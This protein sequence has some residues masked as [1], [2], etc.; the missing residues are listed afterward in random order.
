MS[1]LK[2]PISVQYELT[3]RCPHH[4][5]G[6]YNHLRGPIDNLVQPIGE[7]RWPQCLTILRRIIEAGVFSVVLTGGEPLLRR[8]I[9]FPAIDVLK[10][11][12]IKVSLNTS[13]ILLTAKDLV[14]FRNRGLDG[15]LISCPSMDKEMYEYLTQR[16][17]FDRFVAAMNLVK[18]SGL[19]YSANMVI[20]A[21]NLSHL[22]DTA[23]A[24]YER[25]DCH[26]FSATPMS[27]N[28]CHPEQQPGFLTS[29]QVTDMVRRL[30]RVGEELGI[31][32]DVF[33]SV[34]AC[35]MPEEALRANLKL[36]RR[37][38][39]AGR[40]VATVGPD[41][42]V[43][44]CGH[45]PMSYGNLLQETLTD[46]WQKMS[47]W[48]LDEY[49]P[50]KCRVCS[51]F[52]RCK[53]GCR[54]SALAKTGDL[55]GIDPWMKAPLTLELPRPLALPELDLHSSYQIKPFAWRQE[56]EERYVLFNQKA[57]SILQINGD[58]FRLI[59]A[60]IEIGVFVPMELILEAGYNQDDVRRVLQILQSKG[61]ISQLN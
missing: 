3:L 57:R 54:I 32:V 33:E 53:G 12:G 31:N 60:L 44:P 56:G 17:T 59:R 10:S 9:V 7:L 30:L 5:L 1:G 50:E 28:A 8:D 42:S 16:H 46:I 43:R 21:L 52:S 29:D 34:V 20:N 40:T 37:T 45:A 13:A 4:C 51:Y 11:H 58:F 14:G 26:Y 19:Q 24:L 35:A 27:L 18:S 39:T 22:E 55:K 6:C 2:A 25:F 47:S 48:R 23:R 36:T 41:G 61:F 15:L 49:L 38:C